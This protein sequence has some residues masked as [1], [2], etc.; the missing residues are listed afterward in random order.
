MSTGVYQFGRNRMKEKALESLC[1]HSK[2]VDRTGAYLKLEKVHIV[3][4]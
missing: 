4:R 3:D 2:V 1:D